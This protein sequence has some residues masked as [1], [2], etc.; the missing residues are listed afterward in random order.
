MKRKFLSGL[1]GAAQ[2]VALTFCAPYVLAQPAQ[3]ATIKAARTLADQPYHD[4]TVYKFGANDFLPISQVTENAAITH[5]QAKIKG[6]TIAYTAT[7]GHLTATDPQSGQPK[8]SV[9]YVAYTAD[10]KKAANR[11]VTF[12]YNGGPGSSSVWL[13]LGAYAPKRIVTGDPATDKPQPFP[14]VDNMQS[15]IDTTD[16]VYVDAVGTGLSE[17][18]APHTN[19]AFWG[20]D[21]DASVFRDFITRYLQVN[22]RAASPKYLFGESYGTPRS[23][24]LANQLEVAG[25]HLTGVILQSAILNYNSNADM[26]TGSFS[27]YMPGYAAVGAFFNMV[28][29]PPTQLAPF[30]SKMRSFAAGKYEPAVQALLTSHTQP[31][32][33]LLAQLQ[34]NTGYPAAQWGANFNLDETTFRSNLIPGYLLG[35]YD[36]RVIAANGSPLAADGDPSDTLIAK[37]FADRMK[38]YLPNGLKYYAATAY[39]MV[40][41]DIIN[42]WVWTH[43]GLAMPDTIPDLASAMYLNPKLKVFS[44]NGYHDLATPFYITEQDLGRLGTVSGLQIGHYP[45]GHMTYLYDPARPSMKYDLVKFYERQM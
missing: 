17:A 44:I 15:L 33:A 24:V 3:P 26:G 10:G 34:A 45:G 40:N 29:P 12:F 13:H 31:S 6:Q 25:T 5:G 18:I 2:I 21:A 36:G 38:D 30:L 19:S 32:P 43:D 35:R 14:F 11:P 4:N 42:A 22:Q 28:T 27:G 23:D 37:P 7:A 9:F 16:M 39:N 8:A 20:V 41:D 1:A